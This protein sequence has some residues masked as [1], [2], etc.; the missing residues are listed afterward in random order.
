MKNYINSMFRFSFIIKLLSNLYNHENKI[1]NGK[2][3]TTKQSVLFK[4]VEQEQDMYTLTHS[5]TIC[6]KLHEQ[7]L[8]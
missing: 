8:N 3:K 4:Q 5:L 6:T 1:Y 7:Q 2:V